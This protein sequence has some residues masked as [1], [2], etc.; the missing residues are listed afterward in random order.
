MQEIW[1]CNWLES[2]IIWQPLHLLS[3]MIAQLKRHCKIWVIALS[4][5]IRPLF[6]FPHDH[7]DKLRLFHQEFSCV[8]HRS[9][10]YWLTTHRRTDAIPD[11]QLSP[12]MACLFH[13]KLFWTLISLI[14]RLQLEKYCCCLKMVYIIRD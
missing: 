8:F 2:P 5:R 13:A 4:R 10:V 9:M 11:L 14:N 7:T 1:I 6:F 12:D 3:E